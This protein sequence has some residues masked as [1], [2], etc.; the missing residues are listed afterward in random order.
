MRGL[1][2][3]ELLTLP[4][5]MRGIGLG[6]PIDVLLDEQAERVVGIELLCGDGAHRFLPFA[7]A[8]IRAGEIAVESALALLDE[9][10]LGYYRERTRRLADADLAAPWVDEHG[11]LHGARTA[12]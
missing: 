3:A 10:D 12:A 1:P 5:R 11:Y 8:Q 9:R 4:V 2:V 7:V 6:H